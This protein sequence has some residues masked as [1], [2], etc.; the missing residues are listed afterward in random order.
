[1]KLL[2]QIMGLPKS[3]TGEMNVIIP[4]QSNK[5]IRVAYPMKQF[6]GLYEPYK[7]GDIIMVEKVENRLYYGNKPYALGE[8][9][10]NVPKG[11]YGIATPYGYI[12]FTPDSLILKHKNGG[13]LTL[14]TNNHV[15]VPLGSLGSGD[16]VL[17]VVGGSSMGSPT[18]WR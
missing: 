6:L 1:M 5:D 2:A 16:N 9:N 3:S 7:V 17:K 11:S 4:S 15:V 12:A 8:Y 10:Q 18:K 13:Q 14:T